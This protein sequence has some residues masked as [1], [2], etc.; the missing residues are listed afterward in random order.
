MPIAIRCRCGKELLIEAAQAGQTCACP[1]CRAPVVVPGPE[2]FPDPDSVGLMPLEPAE[3]DVVEFVDDEEAGTYAVNE[4]SPAAASTAL[5]GELGR[6]RVGSRAASYLAYA[7]DHATGLAAAGETIHLLDLR[8][9]KRCGALREHHDPVTCLAFSA[10]GKRVLSADEDGGLLLWAPDTGRP[11]RWLEGHR[12]P[13]RTAAF[14]RD[15]HWAV[16]GGDDG[17]TRLWEVRTGKPIKLY[18]ARWDE[19]VT[20]A[21]FAPDGRRILAVGDEG[22]AWLWSF[23]TGEPVRRFKGRVRRLGSAAFGRGGAVA[24][25][26]ASNA[27][28]VCQWDVATGQ[29]IRCFVDYVSRQPRVTRVAVVPNGARLLVVGEYREGDKILGAGPLIVTPD[30]VT[31]LALSGFNAGLQASLAGVGGGVTRYYLQMWELANEN[32]VQTIDCALEKPRALATSADGH[33]ALASF[34]DGTVRVYAL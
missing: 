3:F 10:D 33:R 21:C 16:S 20:G 28:E 26:A 25:A 7:P 9:G 19:R 14:S 13:V 4:Q 5:T 2:E 15:G 11:L 18:E 24:V 1:S 22:R 12:G 8:A 32:P 23:K 17:T 31:G 6:I 29:P 34:A 27:F 30:L